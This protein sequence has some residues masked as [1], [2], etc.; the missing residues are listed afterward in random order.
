VPAQG[1]PAERKP[2]PALPCQE[3]VNNPCQKTFES[4]AQRPE[5][6]PSWVMNSQSEVRSLV[7]RAEKKWSS[8][9]R[10]RRRRRR[11][12]SPHLRH[13]QRVARA[14]PVSSAEPF[15]PLVTSR[16]CSRLCLLPGMDL[17][18]V[19]SPEPGPAAAWGPSKVSERWSRQVSQFTPNAG[20]RS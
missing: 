16:L 7:Y 6:Q 13:R 14:P 15:L 12:L 18:G 20:L 17:V 2:N 1:V 10:G 3:L 19:S 9:G 4:E 5:V 11:H 8:S